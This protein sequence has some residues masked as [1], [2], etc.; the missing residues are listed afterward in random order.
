MALGSLVPLP[1]RACQ[2]LVFHLHRVGL[3]P[4]PKTLLESLG[5]GHGPQVPRLGEH[6]A[7]FQT[8]T[9]P[10]CSQFLIALS[11]EDATQKLPA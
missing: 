5:T 8:Q 3:Q 11:P 4:L 1:D 7:L 10:S 9:P 6:G 2:T